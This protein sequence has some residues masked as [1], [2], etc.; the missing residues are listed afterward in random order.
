MIQLNTDTKLPKA[1]YWYPVSMIVIILLGIS[2]PLGLLMKSSSSIVGMFII[3]AILFSPL[4]LITFLTFNNISFNFNENNITIKSGILI[5]HSSSI[6]Y[7]SIQNIDCMSGS[8]MSLL[9]IS[10]VKIWTASSGQM[11]MRNGRSQNEPNGLLILLRE[12]AEWL[13]SFILNKQSISLTT[14]II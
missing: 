1:V 13:K 2:V 6:P 8:L 4:L 3:F 12:D 14:P 5:K 11:V 10:K 7:T 9:H